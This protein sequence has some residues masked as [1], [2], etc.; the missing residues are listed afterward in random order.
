MAHIYSGDDKKSMRI[1]VVATL[2]SWTLDQYCSYES[3]S[4]KELGTYQQ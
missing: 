3:S 2:C 1:N 4:N